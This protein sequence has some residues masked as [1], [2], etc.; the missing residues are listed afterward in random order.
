[1]SPP[2]LR[3]DPRDPLPIWRQIEDRVRLL[4]A[5]GALLAG[6]AVPSVR[7]MAKELLIN[8]ATVAKAYQR[9]ADA[10]VLE[11]R[12]GEGTFVSLEPPALGDRG[13]ER[14]LLA[15]AQ[16]YAATALALGA[17]RTEAERILAAAWRGIGDGKERRR[18]S[19]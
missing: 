5:S 17:S 8:P 6:D 3:I 1:M 14:E 7:E 11:V 18:A 15:A 4:V 13:R 12:R 19:E 9:L 2:D 10:G 16:R